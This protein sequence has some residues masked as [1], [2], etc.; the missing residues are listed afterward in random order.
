MTLLDKLKKVYLAKAICSNC[1]WLQDIRIPKGFT[2]ERYIK[3]E[4]C[5]C[6]NCGCATLRKPEPTREIVK[7]K[8]KPIEDPK[9]SKKEFDFWTGKM[10]D[11]KN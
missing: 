7:D 9:E 1:G 2:F 3:N 10:G 11:R 6:E 8:A 4:A 5:V